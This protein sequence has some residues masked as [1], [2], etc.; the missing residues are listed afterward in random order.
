VESCVDAIELLQAILDSPTQHGIVV[1]DAEGNIRLWNRGAARIFQY[2]DDEIIGASAKVLFS[3]DDVA[4]GIPDKEMEN[5]RRKGYSGD[6][7]WH[8]RKDGSLFWADGMIYPV[9][10]RAGEML[11]YVKILRDATEE[12]KS[13]DETSR[14]ALEDS[15]TGL[16]NRAEFHNRF[17]DMRASAQRHGRLLI[18]LL[19]DLDGFKQVNDRLGHAVGDA[20]LQQTAH[21]M[22]AALRDTDFV[23]RLGGDEFV[24]LLPDAESPDVGGALADKLVQILSRPFRLNQEEVQ[25]SASIGVSVYPQDAEELEPLFTKADLALYQ[26]KAEGRSAYRFYTAQMD[27]SAHRRSQDLAHVRRAIK[28]RSFHLH[29]QP[30]VDAI[31]GAPIAVEALLRCAHPYFAGY[32]T[33]EIISLATE[34]GRMR[35]L[36]LWALS[37]AMQQIRL[38]QQ[39]GH[40]ELALSVNFGRIEFTE[41][42]FA[43]RVIDLLTKMNLPPAQLE[44]DLPETQL[45]GDFDASQL[46]AL[47]DAGVRI[48]VDDLGVGGLALRHLFEMPIDCVKLDQRCLPHLPA[49]PRSRA[50]VMGATQL[51]HILGIRVVAERVESEEQ[52]AFLRSYCDGMQ[53]RQ[54]APPMSA[55]AMGTWLKASMPSV[56]ML[57]P[58]VV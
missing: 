1:T 29:Y 51:A 17:V 13:G 58:N 22:R 8:M 2:R 50:L 24:I 43:Q 38:W 40:P 39:E 6:F 3:P 57:R 52:M 12:K 5:A 30:L 16:P 37:D 27:V 56:G 54:I 14:L 55:T 48:A 18:L 36:G 44:I 46:I 53:G 31:T 23:A 26:A 45:V 11:G 25:I 49:D 21:R 33:E 32:P 15:L 42:R 10:N 41:P 28:D 20:L 34:T 19:M 47:H 7:R 4:H 9:R 35:R